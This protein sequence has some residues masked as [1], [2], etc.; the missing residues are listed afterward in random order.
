MGVSLLNK[1]RFVKRRLVFTG[2]NG[3]APTHAVVPGTL[4]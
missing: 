2:K 4:V 1:V 3:R